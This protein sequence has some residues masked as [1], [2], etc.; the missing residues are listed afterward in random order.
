MQLN[1]IGILLATIIQ[2]I[3]GAIWY[4]LFFRKLWGQIHEF[5]K[6][7]KQVQKKMM[8]SM[9]PFYALQAL[10]T[11]ITTGVLALFI[12]YLPNDW[13]SY[14]MAGFLWIGFVVPTQVSAVIFGGTPE[15][16]IV[17]KIAVQAGA[18][19]ICLESAAIILHFFL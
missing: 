4:S 2:F 16:W 13:N 11:L 19:L 6:L 10:M 8:Q 15:K 9:G 14:G 7:P 18:S 5:D 17:K 3:I 1:I 12:A